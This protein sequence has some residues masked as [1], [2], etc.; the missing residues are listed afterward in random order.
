[1]LII[2]L[3]YVLCKTLPSFRKACEKRTESREQLNFPDSRHTV[4]RS[5]S[6][7]FYLYCKQ[8]IKPKRLRHPES[9]SD[10]EDDGLL[11]PEEREA[12]WMRGLTREQ[13][14]RMAKKSDASKRV[15]KHYDS[16][17]GSKEKLGG[18]VYLL[19]QQ[20]LDEELKQFRKFFSPDKTP[21]TS[22]PST[23]TPKPGEGPSTPS[24]SFKRETYSEETRSI[25]TSTTVREDKKEGGT[26]KLPEET[27]IDSTIR[28][29]K[30]RR[31]DDD[32]PNRPTAVVCF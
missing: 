6:S 9:D 31:D 18:P 11:T 16:P 29:L 24:G 3:N 17:T 4:L 20:E 23:S 27:S 2:H 8:V 15:L 12:R 22:T 5:Q 7:D 10:D 21:S 30:R 14:I 25:S 26:P 1:M 13:V 19:N 28:E 32:S